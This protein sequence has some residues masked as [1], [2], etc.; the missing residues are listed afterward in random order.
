[1]RSTEVTGNRCS[2]HSLLQSR[3]LS[4]QPAMSMITRRNGVHKTSHHENQI[5]GQ[6]LLGQPLIMPMPM[7]VPLLLPDQTSQSRSLH[8]TG[9]NQLTA[10]E[11]TPEQQPRLHTSDW[12]LIACFRFGTAVPPSP[13]YLEEK[14]PASQARFP[15]SSRPAYNAQDTLVAQRQCYVSISLYIALHHVYAAIQHV[16]AVGCTA[17][18][19]SPRCL[20][21]CGLWPDILMLPAL[22]TAPTLQRQAPA[23]SARHPDAARCCHRCTRRDGQRGDSIRQVWLGCF[24]TMQYATAAAV[25]ENCCQ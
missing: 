24:T 21:A 2:L 14:K 22:C 19:A 7:L 5:K 4:L 18:T 10:G 3:T 12:H 9:C 20:A 23:A 25:L 17:R 1:M 13:V 11:C 8:R 6:T 15:F 16:D